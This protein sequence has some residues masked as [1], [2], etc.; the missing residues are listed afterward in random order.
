MMFVPLAGV[1]LFLPSTGG[2]YGGA[3]FFSFAEYA[4]QWTTSRGLLLLGLLPT[5]LAWVLLRQL[6]SVVVAGWHR[7][8]VCVGSLVAMLVA[9]WP[10]LGRWLGLSWAVAAAVTVILLLVGAGLVVAATVECRG[11]VDRP[12]WWLMVL[13]VVVM[14]GWFAAT[15]HMAVSGFASDLFDLS[16]AAGFL[17]MPAYAAAVLVHDY[18]MVGG[19]TRLPRSSAGGSPAELEDGL[20][21]GL[22]DPGLQLLFRAPDGLGLLDVG[23]R[24][25]PE[26]AAPP[27]R[28]QELTVSGASLGVL[29]WSGDGRP[30]PARLSVLMGVVAVP[31]ARARMQLGVLSRVIDLT[32]SRRRMLEAETAAR[33]QIERDLHD[34]AQQRLTVS[35]MLLRNA[36]TASD[37]GEVTR[38]ASEQVEAALR[39]I[40]SLARGLH[41]A[42]QASSGLAVAV[43]ELAESLPFPVEVRV[44]AGRLPQLV[45]VTAYLVV[46]ECMT[47]VVKY[48]DATRVSVAADM[49]G[50][51]VLLRVEDDGC[52][53]ADPDGGTGL[54]GLSDRVGALGGSMR[55]DSPVGG[56]TRVDVAIPVTDAAAL[57]PFGS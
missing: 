39:E 20:R 16:A 51:A 11:Q 56:G 8:A 41:S 49:A 35:L 55:I 57:Q 17:L 31:L 6:P 37:P 24:A 52:G 9:A 13:L 21:L 4:A 26:P 15:A 48:A 25:V 14:L 43:E 29:L 34:G 47:N 53:G 44:E 42:T 30:D 23:G 45:E 40:Q 54:V 1:L 33:R 22:G 32:D 5:I 28:L 27:S 18:V 12:L 19:A 36:S 2:G 7:A 3:G 38:R 10:M 50:G 46:K